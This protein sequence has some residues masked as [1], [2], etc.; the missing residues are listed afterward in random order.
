MANETTSKVF[1]STDHRIHVAPEGFVFTSD[2]FCVPEWKQ[3][4]APARGVW[5][6]TLEENE[7]DARETLENERCPKCGTV[8]ADHYDNNRRWLPCAAL[9]EPGVDGEW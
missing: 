7:A 2:G 8:L 6:E 1:E 9:A 3:H 5:I 4:S